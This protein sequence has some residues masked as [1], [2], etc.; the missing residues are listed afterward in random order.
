MRRTFVGVNVA[1][2]F[3]ACGMAS[4]L[5]SPARAQDQLPDSGWQLASSDNQNG[6]GG[7]FGSTFGNA[8]R[9]SAAQRPP[10]RPQIAQP[11]AQYYV[12]VQQY[13]AYQRSAPTYGAARRGDDLTT[14]SM[15]GVTASPEAY[16]PR[17]VQPRGKIG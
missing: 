4:V 15:Y 7:F 6:N 8:P 17:Y 3:T 10:A 16:Q 9:A 2:F 5:G 13:R 11:R 1:M 12:P 14:G